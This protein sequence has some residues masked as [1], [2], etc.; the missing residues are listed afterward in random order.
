ML[1]LFDKTNIVS[2]IERST[3]W[4]LTMTSN[5]PS[6]EDLL[7]MPIAALMEYQ[8]AVARVLEEAKKEVAAVASVVTARFS[9][10]IKDAY[11][12]QDKQH[13]TVRVPVWT[14]VEAV[15]SATKKV[16]WDQSGLKAIASDMD[17][18]TVD[19]FFKIK[20]DVSETVF[21]GLA[22]D[23]PRR[24]LF[25]AARTVEYGEPKVTLVKAKT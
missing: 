5:E 9:D 1:T 6:K 2:D 12:A 23:D 22:P 24:P 15:G 16:S 17:W 20:F 7:N 14:D 3:H 18:L 19:H 21:N 10:Q 11:T 4:E 8:E 13:G 25:E